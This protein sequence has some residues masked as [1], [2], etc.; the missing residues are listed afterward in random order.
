MTTR[1]VLLLA[2][3]VYQLPL[4]H[5]C[6]RRGLS[7][8]VFDGSPDAPGLTVADRGEVVDIS[9]A[10]AVIRAARAVSPMAV[11]SITSEV[12][13]RTTAAAAAAL[14]LPGLPLAV[15]EAATD[16]VIMRQR[17]QAAGMPVPSFAQARSRDEASAAAARIGYP[18]I[19][20]PVDSSGSRG[21]RRVESAHD[22]G[23]ACELA[24]ANS[25]SRTM[26]V[27]EFIDGLECT[28]ETFSYRGETAVLGTS[29]KKHLPFPVCVSVDL[30]YP[31]ALSA[32]TR[33]AVEHAAMRAV[34]AIGLESGPGHIEV[35]VTDRGPV[36]IEIAARGGGYRIFSEI[37]P[38]IS[39][40]DPV[41]CVLD[42][43][44][45]QPPAFRPTRHEAAVLRFFTPQGQGVLADVRGVEPARRGEGIV[46]V[47]IES[48]IGTP[49]AGITRDGE[50][51]GY[52]IAIG[53]DRPTVLKRADAAEAL[54]SFDFAPGQS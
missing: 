31:P 7:T 30:T 25:K 39:G 52:L 47:V 53:P 22:L 1:P 42:L 38:L 46:D 32:E 23:S 27:E 5:A 18:V 48:P 34:K 33:V 51:P 15:A 28:V 6:K 50:R 20:K 44:L 21:V 17:F 19:V 9:D 4:I 13:V 2:G 49:Y 10:D 12:T 45:G 36:V 54:V 3:G 14:G 35:M 29:D 43:A 11:A 26:I 40:V 41:E 16:K 24:I 37:L 8:V